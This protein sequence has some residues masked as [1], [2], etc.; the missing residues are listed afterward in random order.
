MGVVLSTSGEIA[1]GVST[2]ERFRRPT[3]LRFHF[4][5]TPVTERPILGPIDTRVRAARRFSRQAKA[6]LGLSISPEA[7]TIIK[8]PLIAFA[9]R[10]ERMFQ[11]RV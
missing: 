9:F 11:V 4:H 2:Y 5:E 7:A 8:S 3:S 10:A 1:K 6:Q